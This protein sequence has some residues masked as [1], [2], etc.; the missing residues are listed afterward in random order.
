MLNLL[1]LLFAKLL[2]KNK[3]TLSSEETRAKIGTLYEGLNLEETKDRYPKKRQIWVHPLMFMFRRTIFIAISVLLFNYPSMQMMGHCLLTL[4]SAIYV[5]QDKM[6]TSR[7]RQAVEL[8]NEMLLL[9]ISQL[10]QQCMRPMEPE[11]LDIIGHYILAAV[12]IL[13]SLNIGLM[14]YMIVLGFLEKRRAKTIEDNKAA[15]F[16]YRRQRLMEM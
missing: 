5:A 2:H 1:P 10:I 9:L 15:Y 16:E 14:I 7:A 13:C 6:Y 12:I 11:T 4:A 3:E 8:G